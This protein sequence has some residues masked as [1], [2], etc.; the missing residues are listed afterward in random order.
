MK[1]YLSAVSVVVVLLFALE[2]WWNESSWPLATAKAYLLVVVLG[3][4][5]VALHLFLLKSKEGRPAAF[6]NSFLLAMVMKL[7]L[8][9]ILLAIVI[10]TETGSKRPIIVH[11]ALLYAVFLV[12]D[13]A[14]LYGEM[15]S[16][17][18]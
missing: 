1:K 7:M 14:M 3:F 4:I 6:V 17:E 8:Y 9:A 18:H 10:F 2:W 12:F 5:S 15:R 13:V 16:R 11:F